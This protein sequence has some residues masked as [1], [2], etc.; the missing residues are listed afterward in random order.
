MGL[1]WVAGDDVKKL[2]DLNPCFVGAGGEGISDKDGNPV[3][4][5]EGIGLSFDCPC[6]CGE[7]S[8]VYFE[9]PLDGGL[10]RGSP[11]WKRRGDTFETL[12]LSPSLL[13]LTGCK[14]HGHLV[15]GEMV[16]C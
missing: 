2:T 9:N 13:K 8:F 14:W 3:P 15:N 12:T 7:G 16:P 10:P 1:T 6:G 4:R 5:R 11:A